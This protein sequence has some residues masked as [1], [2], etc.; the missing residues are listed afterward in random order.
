MGV[1]VI[2]IRVWVLTRLPSVTSKMMD[3]EIENQRQ[4]QDHLN[5]QPEYRNGIWHRNMYYINN[6]KR[7]K[8]NNGR[9]RTAKARKNKKTWRKWHQQIDCKI[10]RGHS[11]ISG[12]EQQKKK[13]WKRFTRVK[14]ESFLKLNAMAEIS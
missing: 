9:N 14:R 1:T 5:I 7:K 12:N 4:N 13:K 11:Q 2:P 6:E 3:E 8:T 10:R